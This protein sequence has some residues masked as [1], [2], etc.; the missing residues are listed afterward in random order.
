MDLVLDRIRKLADNCT[1]LQVENSFF[2][3]G[4][5]GDVGSVGDVGFGGDGG[6]GGDVED[7]YG[8]EGQLH[9]VAGGV[10]GFS[11]C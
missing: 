9:R 7:D 10:S 11:G 8:C 1:G 5:S 3:V 2:D 6:F 4:L